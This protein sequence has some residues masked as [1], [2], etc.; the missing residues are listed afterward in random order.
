MIYLISGDDSYR[1]WHKLL[2]IKRKYLDA[3]MGDTD[4]ATLDGSSLTAQE[5]ANQTRT[6]PFLAKS[7][8]VIVRNL[9]KEGKKEVTEAV[10]DL[11]ADIPKSTVLFFY[12]SGQPD[13]RGKLYQT[14]N[15]P[16]QAQDFQPLIGQDLLDQIR[17]MAV[18]LE[19]WLLPSQVQAIARLLG[20]DLWR[21]DQE[22]QKLSL[23]A[24]SQ[25]GKVSDADLD[26]LIDALPE[27]RIFDLTDAFG[28]RNS[29]QVLRLLSYVQA[30]DSD[31]G[32][33]SMIAGHYRNLLLIADGQRRQVPRHQLAQALKLHPFVFDKAFSQ[34]NRYTY[35]ELVSCYRYLLQ[36]DL[37]AKQSLFEPMVGLSVLA[38]LL[39]NKEIKLPLLT[40]ESLVA[41]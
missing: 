12:E 30:D 18:E 31:L 15:K 38:G 36:L 41:A 35:K 19:L 1:S 4:L 20:S 2:S 34:A 13:K 10:I 29:P 32:L 22:L 26:L 33:L 17:E 37:A 11:L 9:L 3:S 6:A 27:S 24:Q 23:F 14:L 8:L 39:G 7:R 21:I 5:F 28:N 16:K 40:E 25:Q